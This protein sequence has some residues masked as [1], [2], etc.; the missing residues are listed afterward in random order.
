MLCGLESLRNG[1]LVPESVTKVTTTPDLAR[2]EPGGREVSRG[3]PFCRLGIPWCNS[4]F[5]L[6]ESRYQ[7][8]IPDVYP[9]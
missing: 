7:Q 9:P 3:L 4:C 6:A 1:P 5:V 8:G 2:R